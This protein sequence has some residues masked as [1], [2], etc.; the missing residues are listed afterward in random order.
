MFN[1]MPIFIQQN[2]LQTKAINGQGTQLS[3]KE[4]SRLMQTTSLRIRKRM[5]FVL[6][7]DTAVN[8]FSCFCDHK[9]ETFK[10]YDN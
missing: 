9:S 3:R 5:C 8:E 4:V 7:K 1:C 10:I 6:V 2:T